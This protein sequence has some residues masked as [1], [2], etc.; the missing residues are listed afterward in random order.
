[1]QFAC[2]R[3]LNQ[4]VENSKADGRRFEFHKYAQNGSLRRAAIIIVVVVLARGV[5]PIFAEP[6]SGRVVRRRGDGVRRP[7]LVPATSKLA[8]RDR[9]ITVFVENAPI[10]RILP[11]RRPSLL[12]QCGETGHRTFRPG[13][14]PILRRDRIVAN[15]NLF[16]R[17]WGRQAFLPVQADPAFLQCRGCIRTPPPTGLPPPATCARHRSCRRPRSRRPGRHNPAGSR[18]HSGVGRARAP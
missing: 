3:Q 9:P 14:N 17:C 2:G 16:R 8:A 7:A 15:F 11:V 4:N 1:M 12:V 13:A 5:W 18:Q 10:A 6:F